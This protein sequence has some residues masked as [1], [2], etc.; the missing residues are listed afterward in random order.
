[1]RRTYFARRNEAMTDHDSLKSFRLL[2]QRLPLILPL[3]SK[4]VILNP[5]PGHFH[6]YL[7]LRRKNEW[8]DLVALQI[9]L[10]S[11]KNRELANYSRI[12]AGASK[13]ILLIEFTKTPHWRPPDLT[14][15]CPRKLRG[16]K[17]ANC[18]H[19]MAVK[20]HVP[21]AG[22]LSTRLKVMGVK[23]PFET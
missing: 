7:K 20:E 12:I 8:A 22:F 14:C 1:M 3:V 17:F 21:L 11:D 4:I 9:F 2:L 16:R 10:G 19:L 18:P 13:P 5:R 23:E 15:S 6:C